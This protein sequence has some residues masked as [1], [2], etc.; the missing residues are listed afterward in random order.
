[1]GSFRKGEMIMYDPMM[2]AEMAMADELG[3]MDTPTHEELVRRV[4]D[5][6]LV[7]HESGPITEE[8]IENACFECDVDFYALS[9]ID[10]D[11]LMEC[12]LE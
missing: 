5:V 3:L 4:Q 9:P 7:N 1:M 11:W 6:L 8:D 12:V 10:I 2:G